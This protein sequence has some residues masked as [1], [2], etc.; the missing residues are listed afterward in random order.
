MAGFAAIPK[1]ITFPKFE[2]S[3]VVVVVL[4]E[5]IISSVLV[6]AI[7]KVHRRKEE[8]EDSKAQVALQE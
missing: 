7:L 2:P 8:Q 6:K 1:E 4:D 3:F 5:I